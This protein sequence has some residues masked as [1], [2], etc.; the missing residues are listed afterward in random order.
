MVLSRCDEGEALA[1]V[2]RAGPTIGGIEQDSR[3]DR[4]LI[5][6]SDV[7]ENSTLGQNCRA[8]RACTA[9]PKPE[10]EPSIP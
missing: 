8:K 2:S 5:Y 1:T 9:R 6:P 10:R 4:M 3:V 7:R